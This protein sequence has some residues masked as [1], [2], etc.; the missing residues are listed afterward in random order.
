LIVRCR[1]AL[2]LRQIQP[3]V[4]QHHPLIDLSPPESPIDRDVVKT[5]NEQALTRNSAV[6]QPFLMQRMQRPRRRSEHRHSF[7]QRQLALPGHSLPQIL[8]GQKR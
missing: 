4:E 7:R 2:F 6:I 3:A 5:N 1:S 8:P